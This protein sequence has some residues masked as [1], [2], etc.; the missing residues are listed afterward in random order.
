MYFKMKMSLNHLEQKILSDT[1][2]AKGG[3]KIKFYNRSRSKILVTQMSSV[4]LRK[5]VTC[6][7]AGTHRGSAELI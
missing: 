3:F 6:S 1:Q 5:P 4:P 7:F 2:D